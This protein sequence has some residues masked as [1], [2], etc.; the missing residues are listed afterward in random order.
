MACLH[1]ILE[2]IDFSLANPV[3]AKGFIGEKIAGYGFE[4]RWL[5]AVYE[6]VANVLTTPIMGRGSLFTLSRLKPAERLHEVEFYAPLGLISAD[7]LGKVFRSQSAKRISEE[8]AGIIESL[9]FTPHRGMLRGFIDMVFHLDERYYLVDWKSNFLGENIEDYRRERLDAIMERE[10]YVL[11]Y[12]IYAFALHQFL[13]G[14]VKDYNYHDHFGGV[15]YL[16]LRGIDPSR[17]SDYGV[18]FDK[19]E[20]KV[21]DNLTGCLTGRMQND[22]SY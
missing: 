6:T 11:Q 7:R 13:G 1:D 8:V 14:R 10:L 2:H 22:P 20:F 9:D 5:D 4:D 21:I 12:H 16:F 15:L 19:P 3:E 17:G 18:F